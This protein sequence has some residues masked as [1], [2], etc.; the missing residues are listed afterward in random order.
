M[1]LF[2]KILTDKI[3]YTGV[4][5]RPHWIAEHTGHFGD[6]LV[7]F[8][9]PCQVKT[10][11]MVDVEDSRRG[12]FIE[13]KEMLH[14]L[15]ENFQMSLDASIAHQRLLIASIVELL[16]AEIPAQFR[17]GRQGNDIYIR[18]AG[19]PQNL[20]LSVSIVT[21]TAVSTL[22]HLG[23]NIDATGAPVPAI[24]LQA[25]NIDPEA[26]TQKLFTRWVAE[27]DSMQKARCKVSPR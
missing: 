14:F 6:S 8:R 22:L 20:K 16:A 4:E 10:S 2:T 19:N 11:E 1:T 7:A 15:G 13:S 27:F 26:F 24:G 18:E 17:V 9:G 23:L 25:M 21:A 12:L 5:L 3:P